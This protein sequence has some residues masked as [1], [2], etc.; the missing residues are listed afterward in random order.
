VFPP[1]SPCLRGEIF[2]LKKHF[3]LFLLF[4][5]SSSF[6]LF[7]CEC[8]PLSPVNKEAL[9][10][11]NVIFYGQVDSVSPCDTKGIAGAWFT[12]Q[13]LY[14][15]DVPQHIKV[16]FECSSACMMSFAK[17]DQWLI[18]GKFVRFGVL[19][20]EFCEHS[21]KLFKD[22]SQDIYVSAS[23][24]SFSDERELLKT[25]LG[26][27]EVN[28]PGGKNTG[29][30]LA[31]HNDQP[32]PMNKLWLLLVSFAVMLIVYIVSKRMKK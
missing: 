10:P 14:K 18:F 24:G 1:C 16:D 7:S 6:P 32:S 21:R 17:G 20:A 22:A 13:E 4:L 9:L 11:Y 3:I 5:F 28:S 25:L 26:L 31:P 23:Q 8:P 15:G 19:K 12:I 2:R 27:Q 30:G 29:P